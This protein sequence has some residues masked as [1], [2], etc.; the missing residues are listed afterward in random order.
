MD[1]REEVLAGLR[2]IREQREG[3]EAAERRYV[4]RGRE[5]GLSWRTLANA[6]GR[7]MSSLHE[8][9]ADEAPDGGQFPS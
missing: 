9:Y 8:K 1:E 3:Y 7:S 2:A 5:L 4:L 6:L